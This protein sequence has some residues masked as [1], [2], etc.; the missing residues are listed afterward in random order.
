VYVCQWVA[1][2]VWVWVSPGYGFEGLG[3]VECMR[4]RTGAFEGTRTVGVTYVLHLSSAGCE[5]KR[6]MLDWFCHTSFMSRRRLGLAQ[7]RGL[8]GHSLDLSLTKV[9][10]SWNDTKR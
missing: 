5:Q 3:V 1:V 8:G 4:A 2:S 7:L 10:C 6:L 9:V